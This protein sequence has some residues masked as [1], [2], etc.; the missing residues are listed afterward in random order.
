MTR[1]LLGM[2][3]FSCLIPPSLAFPQNPVKQETAMMTEEQALSILRSKRDSAPDAGFVVIHKIEPDASARKVGAEA[4]AEARAQ[5]VELYENGVLAHLLRAGGYVVLEYNQRSDMAVLLYIV[6]QDEAGEP[7]IDPLPVAPP[8]E[9]SDSDSDSPPA[10]GKM[11]KDDALML[12]KRNEEFSEAFFHSPVSKVCDAARKFGGTPADAYTTTD[13][14]LCGEIP[15][16]LEKVAAPPDEVQDLVNQAAGPIWFTQRYAMTLPIYSARPVEAECQAEEAF[17]KLIAEF[18]EEEKES[19][20]CIDDMDLEFNSIA[21]YDQLLEHIHCLKA[22]NAF[23]ETRLA[24]RLNSPAYRANLLLSK[25]P[26][27][28]DVDD[29][30]GRADMIMTATLLVSGWSHTESGELTLAEYTIASD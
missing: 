23:L 20:S 12:I 15:E 21:T 26:L 19:S 25:V 5:K 17:E 14:P 11:S 2:L 27:N 18:A 22:F 28:I 4:L 24:N 29:G 30:R 9:A 16:K 6:T 3:L 1:K 8:E 7:L 10:W 13:D